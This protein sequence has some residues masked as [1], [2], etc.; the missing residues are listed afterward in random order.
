M[1]E[2]KA[3]HYT[4]S[5]CNRAETMGHQSSDAFDDCVRWFLNAFTMKNALHP[6]IWCRRSAGKRKG[7]LATAVGNPRVPQEKELRFNLESLLLNDCAEKCCDIENGGL[8]MET[9]VHN[10]CGIA[11]IADNL[12]AVK[13]LV[14]EEKCLSLEEFREIVRLELS[15][16]GALRLRI[17][18]TRAEIRQRR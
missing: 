11:T 2:E 8:A 15:G 3:L 4:M 18:K 7:A 1:S 12:A 10:L 17:Q 16:S 6:R 13:Q 5:G 14:M 9:Y